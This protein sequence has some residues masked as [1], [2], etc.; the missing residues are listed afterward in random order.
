MFRWFKS[1]Q[2]VF[3]WAGPDISYPLQIN[4]FK[5]ESKFQKS[6]SYVLK[7]GRKLLA[8]GQLYNRLNHCHLG[9]LV[10]SPEFRG[11]GVG[12]LLID[13]LAAKGQEILG[14]TKLSLFVLSD[15]QAAMTLYQKYGFQVAQY[16]QEIPL[17]NC[18]YMTSAVKKE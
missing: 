11:Q 5:T 16:P 12:A 18:L 3:Y 10:V 7:Q 1:E 6:H 15:N 9:R 8:F 17:D 2:S 14:L 13:A 4:R